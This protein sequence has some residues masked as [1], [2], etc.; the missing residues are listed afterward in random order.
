[1]CY[2]QGG[3]QRKE[4]SEKSEV[5]LY[6]L[7]GR[8]C[9]LLDYLELRGRLRVRPLGLESYRRWSYCSTIPLFVA[10]L[11][12][13]SDPNLDLCATPPNVQTSL[14]TSKRGLLVVDLQNDFCDPKGALVPRI[15]L[16]PSSRTAKRAHVRA[17]ALDSQCPVAR[18]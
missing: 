17:H 2:V 3:A 4:S 5:Q 11:P 15:L 13:S 16:P 6:F 18:R 12:L 8:W 7:G 10:K 1:M 9:R 14:M